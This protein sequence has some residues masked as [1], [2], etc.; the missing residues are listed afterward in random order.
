MKKIVLFIVFGLS[1][2]LLS[3]CGVSLKSNETN[4][5]SNVNSNENPVIAENVISKFEQTL[6]TPRKCNIY[7]ATIG[8]ISSES[9]NEYFFDGKA[10][11]STDSNDTNVLFDLDNRH[12]ILSDNG[13][14][15]YTDNGNKFDD[16][17]SYFL[18]DPNASLLDNSVEF[19]FAT[20]E[21]AESEIM[22]FLEQ[23]G[24]KSEKAIIEQT[25]SVSKENFNEY[26][27][28]LSKTAS[29][30]NDAKIGEQAENV[31]KIDSEDF[32]YFDIGFLEDKIPIYS[33]GAY[34]YGEG[35]NDTFAGTRFTIVY[36]QNGIEYVSAFFLYQTDSVVES[37]DI[38]DFP[39]AKEL[40]NDKYENIFFDSVITFDRAE[41]VYL[42]FPQNTLNERFKK[43]VLRPYYAFYGYQSAEIDGETYKSDFTVYFDAVTGKEL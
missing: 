40:L 28:Y 24:L 5:S 29:A 27:A 38:I 21:A 12:G 6:E 10:Q 36:T 20:K 15:F 7:N 42:P 16:A 13:F 37:V 41:L 26:K 2:L 3:G 14:V 17:A 4:T 31:S 8:S 18:N 33:G 35:D 32:Y 43:F 9:M 22:S 19:D 34:Y 30:E 1:L 39:K 11:K 25:Y 23:V